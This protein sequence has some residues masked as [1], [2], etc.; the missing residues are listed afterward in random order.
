MELWTPFGKEKEQ[1]IGF[2]FF[3]NAHACVMNFC[4]TNKKSF[5]NLNFHMEMYTE[6]GSVQ[7]HGV[8]PIFIIGNIYHTKEIARAVKKEEAQKW[9]KN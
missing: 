6:R 9:C 5:E 7:T 2:K 1:A 8:D 3:K 4:V